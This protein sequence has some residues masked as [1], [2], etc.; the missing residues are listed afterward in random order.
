MKYS[1]LLSI[2]LIA[3]YSLISFS[4]QAGFKID[5]KDSPT[6][7]EQVYL[8]D[9]TPSFACQPTVPTARSITLFAEL[10]E[11]EESELHASKKYIEI[12]KY[13]SNLQQSHSVDCLSQLIGNGL[14]S[15][16]SKDQ[17]SSYTPLNI[18][19]EVFR[20]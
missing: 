15:I 8:F 18:K 1:V 19:F 12:S 4:I 11:V 9:L 7:A 2:L 13:F 20:I 3:G 6:T 5:T 14:P 10:I 16:K 17:F